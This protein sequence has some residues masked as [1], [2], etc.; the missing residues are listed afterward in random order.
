[1]RHLV[2]ITILILGYF[3][4]KTWVV[5]I[6]GKITQKFGLFLPT[7]FYSVCSVQH[8]TSTATCAAALEFNLPD[9]LGFISLTCMQK[10][11]RFSFL[12]IY[13]NSLRKALYKKI[14]S[15]MDKWLK[16]CKLTWDMSSLPRK[17][18]KNFSLRLSLMDAWTSYTINAINLQDRGCSAQSRA[19]R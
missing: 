16:L 18:F 6:T 14:F 13:V 1:M 5:W 8:W 9:L 19:C 10:Q 7:G 15:R 17:F 4:P 3:Y 12:S 2:E 11:D